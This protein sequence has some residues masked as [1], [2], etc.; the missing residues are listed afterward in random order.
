M[1]D[2]DKNQSTKREKTMLTSLLLS[3]PGPIVTGIPA[4]TSHSATQIADFLRRTAE[5]VALFISWWVYRRLQRGIASDDAY[6]ARL[7]QMANFA[8]VGAMICS[9]T[10]M[11]VVGVTRLF[12][13][14]AN[15]NVIMGLII[16]VLGVLTNTWFWLRYAH[17]A[18]ELFDPVIEG[19]MRLYRAKSCVDLGVVA[20][21]TSVAVAPNHPVTQYI[22]A[23][24]CIIVAC[25]L[26]YNGVDIIRKNK[27]KESSVCEDLSELD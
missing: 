5:L 1:T 21:L 22:D 26:L 23:S 10:A 6:R 8:V 13:Y 2:L 18:R 11:L 24:G 19:Q 9:G 15:G 3:A 20:A 7:E 25:Y 14:K 12:V 4:I 16:A 27:V 17:M